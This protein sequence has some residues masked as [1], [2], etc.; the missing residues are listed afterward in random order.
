MS[1][2]TLIPA[3][4]NTYAPPVAAAVDNPTHRLNKKNEATKFSAAAAIIQSWKAVSGKIPKH[5]KIQYKG[6][7]LSKLSEYAAVFT[8]GKKIGGSQNLP[9]KGF[10]DIH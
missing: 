6:A 8:V 10:P 2:P 3:N 7:A 9:C 1:R 4:A 5:R